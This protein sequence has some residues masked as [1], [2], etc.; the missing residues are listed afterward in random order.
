MLTESVVSY[1]NI[2]TFL[3]DKNI[4]P[5]CQADLIKVKKCHRL[6]IITKVQQEFNFNNLYIYY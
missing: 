3:L 2:H 4:L 1:I 5:L 6:V